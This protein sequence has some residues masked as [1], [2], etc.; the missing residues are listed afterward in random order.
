MKICKK[1]T[2]GRWDFTACYTFLVKITFISVSML[3]FGYFWL[4]K[5][6]ICYFK[7]FWLHLNVI[8]AIGV[9]ACFQLATK[10]GHF[11]QWTKIVSN[12]FKI[13][14]FQLKTINIDE[15]NKNLLILGIYLLYNGNFEASGVKL[16][17]EV[18][19]KRTAVD[20]NFLL[21]AVRKS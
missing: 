5:Q 18:I 2:K 20:E 4:D 19:S 16:I 8:K 12:H 13:I 11:L 3:E 17:S 14:S 10:N 15:L 6:L 7:E 1:W 21:V 9:K